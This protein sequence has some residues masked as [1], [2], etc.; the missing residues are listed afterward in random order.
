MRE[1]IQLLI[2]QHKLHLEECK[3]ELQAE[4]EKGMFSQLCV[5]QKLKT[6][7]E[8]RSVFI[9]ELESLIS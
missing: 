8:M 7:I 1:Q 5:R 9:S 3:V 4:V 2:V 6:E